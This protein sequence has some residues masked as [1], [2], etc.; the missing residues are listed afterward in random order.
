MYMAVDNIHQ[1][2]LCTTG[3]DFQNSSPNLNIDH[4]VNV[5]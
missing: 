2:M 4:T 5:D 1:Q 3:A